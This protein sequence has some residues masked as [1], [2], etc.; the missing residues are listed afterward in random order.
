MITE[1]KPKRSAVEHLQ[2]EHG[3]RVTKPPADDAETFFRRLHKQV[4][5]TKSR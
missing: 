4:T 1:K 5:N 2:D 3:Y